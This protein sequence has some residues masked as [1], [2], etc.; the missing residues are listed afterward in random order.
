MKRKLKR[1]KALKVFGWI[2]FILSLICSFVII[3]ELI[4]GGEYMG[5]NWLFVL[6]SFSLLIGGFGYLFRKTSLKGD[7]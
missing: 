2:I 5:W 3:N 4:S 6:I 7:S 1:M